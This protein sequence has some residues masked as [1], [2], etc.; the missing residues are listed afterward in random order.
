MRDGDIN[1]GWEETEK[2]SHVSASYD[3]SRNHGV[4]H[5]ATPD[6]DDPFK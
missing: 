4:R 3:Q 1:C 6:V 5:P 2:P